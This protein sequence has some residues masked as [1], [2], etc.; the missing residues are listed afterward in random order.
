MRVNVSLYMLLT[1]L[2]SCICAPK[3]ATN[4]LSDAKVLIHSIVSRTHLACGD[5]VGQLGYSLSD[6]CTLKNKKNRYWQSTPYVRPFQLSIDRYVHR[7]T[8]TCQFLMVLR[9]LILLAEVM[10]VKV[11]LVWVSSDAATFK[12]GSHLFLLRLHCN[13]GVGVKPNAK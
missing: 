6:M 12:S 5:S 13:F 2:S 3:P 8:H 4:S 10:L 1:A 7:R 9:L 11:R